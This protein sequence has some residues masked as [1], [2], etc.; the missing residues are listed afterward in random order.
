MLTLD[1]RRLSTRCRPSTHKSCSR[2]A[3]DGILLA[4]IDQ[5]RELRVQ[6]RLAQD[7][8]RLGPEVLG[9]AAGQPPGRDTRRRANAGRQAGLAR[10]SNGLTI[11]AM[12]LHKSSVGR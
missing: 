2:K 8:R 10:S 7:A 6:P 9:P 3:A 5:R 1:Q 11:I 12:T 4:G